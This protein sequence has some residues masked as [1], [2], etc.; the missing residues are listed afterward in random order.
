MK[1]VFAA[2]EGV[3]YCKT[4]GLADVV[5]A[6][7]PRLAAAGHHILQVHP[8]YKEIDRRRF[9]LRR[10]SPTLSVRLGGRIWR[11]RIWRHE[12]GRRSSALFIECGDL[13]NRPG[14][15]GY[16]PNGDFDDNDLRFSFFSLA[17]LEA[18]R[19][20]KF[21]PDIVHAHDWQTGLL[22]AYLKTNYRNDPVFSKAASV[23][24]IHNLAYLGHFPSASVRQIGMAPA[25]RT[26]AA[27]RHLGGVSFIK[28]GIVFADAVN[29]VSPTYRRE[30]MTS[31]EFGCGMES[32]LRRRRTR[33][34]GILNGLDTTYWNPSS[35]RFLTTRFSRGTLA[36]RR[37]CKANLRRIAGF[38]A[39]V[40][41]PILGFVGRLDRQKGVELLCDIAPTLL[42]RGVQFVF[43]GSGDS[44]LRD[45]LLEL[46]RYN[47][48]QVF[49][50]T[51]FAEPLAHL[52][53][54]GSDLFLMP[55]RY[56]P[57]GL[58]QLIAMRYGAIP[59][60]SP[61]GGLVDTVTDVSRANGTG[62]VAS[63][64]SP[65][66]FLT[67]VIRGLRLLASPERE[68]VQRRGLTSDFSWEA[69]LLQYE[70]IYRNARRWRAAS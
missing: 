58:G 42:K 40:D 30:I 1:I 57:C 54:A 38:P 15:Y 31:P 47:R 28:A 60:V 7:C 59:V 9:K 13:Y 61:T 6:M 48:T 20:L 68:V 16:R 4:G 14:L 62:V 35:D 65:E 2:S 69:A 32:A 50:E 22:P 39:A 51:A 34:A 55:S 29:T 18:I 53:Y 52:I 44:A 27:I 66:A 12:R 56:E 10:E 63:D 17:T 41:V 64:R 45:R 37:R 67:A 36:R 25:G 49:V 70:R 21:Q 43:L 26:A 5:G 33:V 24:T 8:L 3:P 11:F 46:A 23:F 19:F